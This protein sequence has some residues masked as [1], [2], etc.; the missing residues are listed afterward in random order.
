MRTCPHCATANSD[1]AEFCTQCGTR[2]EAASPLSASPLPATPAPSGIAGQVISGCAG[3]FVG[4]AV[5]FVAIVGIFGWLGRYLT[6]PGVARGVQI[7]L[8]AAGAAGLIWLLRSGR[9]LGAA[10]QVFLIATLVT[11]LGAFAL[12][13]SLFL[14]NYGTETHLT[15]KPA[16][17]PAPRPA[18][19]SA[20]R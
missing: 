10:L 4:L 2:L 15:R 12:C 19:P 9:R 20:R 1:E 6:P 8:I 3:V 5:A 16:V 11:A 17:V 13:S 18:L 7:A 14:T